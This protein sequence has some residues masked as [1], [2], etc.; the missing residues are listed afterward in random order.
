MALGKVS[1]MACGAG[2]G[3][4]LTADEHWTKGSCHFMN[5]GD[6]GQEEGD[7]LGVEKTEFEWNLSEDS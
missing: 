2:G 3:N 4:C 5:P 7:G 6:W 1:Q